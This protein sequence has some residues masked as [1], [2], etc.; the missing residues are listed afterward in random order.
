MDIQKV[1][2]STNIQTV[3]MVKDVTGKNETYSIDGVGQSAVATAIAQFAGQ[4]VKLHG[5]IIDGVFK[6]FE[7]PGQWTTTK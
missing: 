3:F 1:F 5:F 2:E 4:V 7:L 6:P